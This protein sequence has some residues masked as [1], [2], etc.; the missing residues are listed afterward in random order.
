MFQ[1]PFKIIAGWVQK[2]TKETGMNKQQKYDITIITIQYTI[3]YTI[4]MAAEV[5]IYSRKWLSQTLWIVLTVTCIAQHQQNLGCLQGN[6][7]AYCPVPK[8]SFCVASLHGRLSLLGIVAQEHYI[9]CSCT[10]HFLAWD[11]VPNTLFQFPFLFSYP[12]CQV[13]D[14]SNNG[15]A[16]SCSS[17]YLWLERCPLFACLEILYSSSYIR[18]KA[19]V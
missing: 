11:C 2:T 19:S 3:Q 15:G 18:N 7:R 13:P 9:Q 16:G 14:P 6:D 10:C 8:V 5:A 12:L 4:Q 17:C 1:G